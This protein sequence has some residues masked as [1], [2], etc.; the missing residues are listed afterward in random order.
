MRLTY[1][2][3]RES[4]ADGRKLGASL[5]LHNAEKLGARLTVRALRRRSRKECGGE[6]E[7]S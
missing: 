1:H 5:V 7:E 3:R 2:T 4:V 6:N